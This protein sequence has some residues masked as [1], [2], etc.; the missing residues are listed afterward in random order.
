MASPTPSTSAAFVNGTSSRGEKQKTPPRV[1]EAP[2]PPG[3]QL[4]LYEDAWRL[5]QRAPAS[6]R[7][8]I[9][10]G[11]TTSTPQEGASTPQAQESTGLSCSTD[12]KS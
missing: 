5:L 1:E 6:A 11:P 7:Q 8:L 4:R 10:T 2:F 9:L 12:G 3:G